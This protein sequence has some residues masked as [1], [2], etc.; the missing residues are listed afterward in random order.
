MPT[1]PEPTTVI[2]LFA[3]I[4]RDHRQTRHAAILVL[5]LAFA[6]AVVLAVVLVVLVLFGATGA[7]AVGGV[8]ALLT[9]GIAARRSRR[10]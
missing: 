4:V 5:S 8:S 7:A 10:R 3:Q 6:L 9:A 1:K 2:A